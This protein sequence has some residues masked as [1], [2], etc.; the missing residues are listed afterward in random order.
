MPITPF[1]YT[2]QKD[3]EWAKYLQSCIVTADTLKEYLVAD[4]PD[5]ASLE[6]RK[7]RLAFVTDEVGGFTMAFND[8]VAWRRVQDRDI[9]S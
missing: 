6:G 9:C 7:I 5:P 8:G 3:S 2:P 4:L 1:I